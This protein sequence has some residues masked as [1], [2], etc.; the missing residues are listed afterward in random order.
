M[1]FTRVDVSGG[2]SQA[3][4]NTRHYVLDDKDVTA[5]VTGAT[6]G[7]AAATV[8]IVEFRQMV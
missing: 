4:I 8:P 3:R 5:Q 1:Y 7:Q 6:A 2:A